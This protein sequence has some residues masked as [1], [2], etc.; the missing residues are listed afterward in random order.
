MGQF[1]SLTVYSQLIISNSLTPIQS[2]LFKLQNDFL[3]GWETFQRA[4][5]GNL[6]KLISLDTK[7][8]M[9]FA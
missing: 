1:I 7:R 3:V 6:P 5:D 4:P 8:Q 2:R 9:R